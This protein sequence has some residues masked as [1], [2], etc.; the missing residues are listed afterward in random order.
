MEQWAL[1]AVDLVAITVL[2]YGLYFW[3]H[4]RADLAFAFLLV[5]V[6]V[7]AVAA[8][9]SSTQAGLG[10]GLGLFGVLSIIRLRS[11]EIDQ[12]EVAYYFSALALGLVAGLP[13]VP[14][15]FSLA[16]MALVLVAVAVGDHPSLLGRYRQQSIQLDRAYADESALRAHVESLLGATVH[17]IHVRKLDLVN[18]STLVDVRYE[19][20]A[21]RSTSARSRI[22]A[23]DV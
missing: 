7:L 9:L 23:I 16:L 8:V 10:L 6:G 22:E 5:N 14:V 18:D 11:Q 21:H 17:R 4:R 3:R 20:S 2:A 13:G 1:I 12:R 19:T 15:G